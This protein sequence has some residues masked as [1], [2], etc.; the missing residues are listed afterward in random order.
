MS[1]LHLKNNFSRSIK[2]RHE[3]SLTSKTAES[4]RRNGRHVQGLHG[5]H[6]SGPYKE[7]DGQR[8]IQRF[9]LQ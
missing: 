9:E 4:H 8:A 6:R 7:H 3:G 2:F 1:A 5:G